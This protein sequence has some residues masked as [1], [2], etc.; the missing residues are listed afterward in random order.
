MPAPRV[1]M[2]GKAID[3]KIIIAGGY[4]STYKQNCYS[5]DIVSDTWTELPEYFDTSLSYYSCDVID[6]T[7]YYVGSYPD[8]HPGDPNRKLQ[9][10]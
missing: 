9:T 4:D 1:Y 5:Y 6:G 7:L 8:G 3:G 2:G 10:F